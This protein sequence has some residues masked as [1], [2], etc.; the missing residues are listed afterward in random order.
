MRLSRLHYVPPQLRIISHLFIWKIFKNYLKYHLSFEGC[1]RPLCALC[2]ALTLCT[3][4]FYKRSSRYVS[5]SYPTWPCFINTILEV[6]LPYNIMYMKSDI[7]L[8][9]KLPWDFNHAKY[10]RDLKICTSHELVLGGAYKL[11]P[12]EYKCSIMNKLYSMCVFLKKPLVSS[13]S[14]ANINGMLLCTVTLI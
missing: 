13:I 11:Y 2:E 5:L 3:V 1:H 9:H 8:T 14:T 6:L 10:P 12:S 4:N 7:Y